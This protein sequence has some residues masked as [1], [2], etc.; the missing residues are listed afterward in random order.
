[1]VSPGRWL[2][3]L[4]L[5]LA[6]AAAGLALERAWS[7]LQA[8]SD[9]RLMD[10]GETRPNAPARVQLA[11]ALALERAGHV[12]DALD[13]Y[14]EVD[15]LGTPALRRAAR[16]NV[17][18]LYLARGLAAAQ[19]EGQAQRAMV[20]LQLAKAGYRAALRDAPDDWNARYNLELALR[21]LPDME[22]RNWRRS[23]NEPEI[24]EA[25]RKDKAAWSEMVGTPRGMH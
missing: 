7:A 2:P 15:V 8:G 21:V 18:N 1:M 5:L 24:D 10:A 19:D 9:N 13:I 20:L 3:P 4:C 22:A 16:V 14:A 11:H 17:A 6:L 23:G 25:Q 12:D